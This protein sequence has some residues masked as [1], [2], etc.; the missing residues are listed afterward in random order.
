MRT[1]ALFAKF[2]VAWPILPPPPQYYQGYTYKRVYCIVCCLRM[3]RSY[4]LIFRLFSLYQ[5]REIKRQRKK[6]VEKLS[7]FPSD[8]LTFSFKGRV[9]QILRNSMATVYRSSY[10]D[11]YFVFVV[12][13]ILLILSPHTKVY[14]RS[15]SSGHNF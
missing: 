11:G 3:N 4:P 12:V 14:A 15:F 5:S 2:Y 10:L 8:L 1:W 6:K 7:L 9:H 13:D